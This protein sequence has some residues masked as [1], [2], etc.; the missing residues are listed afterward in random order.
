LSDAQVQEAIDELDVAGENRDVARRAIRE[1]GDNVIQA[2]AELDDPSRLY[3]FVNQY[4]ESAT[5]LIR[6]FDSSENVV[7]LLKLDIS[8]P[9]RARE[10]IVRYSN[11]PADPRFPTGRAE[12]LV[13]DIQ[14]DSVRKVPGFDSPIT[15]RRRIII[16]EIA[17]A[18][19]PGNLRGY[20]RE[21]RIVADR[22][23]RGDT[24]FAIG[25]VIRDSSGDDIVDI[26]VE[27]NDAAIESGG[28]IS[29]TKAQTKLEAYEDAAQ[30]NELDLNGKTVTFDSDTGFE[31]SQKVDIRQTARDIESRSNGINTISIKFESTDPAGGDDQ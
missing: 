28:V 7:S 4:G 1:G 17:D 8:R 21:I 19:G 14:T 3:Q 9:N 5:D 13:E 18:G 6:L 10:N 15:P 25:R 23:R 2:I 12:Q 16:D 30:L 29:T 24:V 20:Q 26:D 31:E 11:D 22:I 27:L